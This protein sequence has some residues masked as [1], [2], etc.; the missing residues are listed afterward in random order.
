MSVDQEMEDRG[1]LTWAPVRLLPEAAEFFLTDSTA[2]SIDLGP[3][4][5]CTRD[6]LVRVERGGQHVGTVKQCRFGLLAAAYGKEEL[7]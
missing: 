2:G 3:Y 6:G 7:C 1:P 5:I 4:R